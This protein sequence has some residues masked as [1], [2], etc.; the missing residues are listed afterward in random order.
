MRRMPRSSGV[1]VDT[2]AHNL[3]LRRRMHAF[4]RGRGKGVG[5]VEKRVDNR[6]RHARAQGPAP[7]AEKERAGIL[8]TLQIIPCWSPGWQTYGYPEE[9]ED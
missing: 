5:I 1:G 4:A 7:A 8:I 9:S 3:H 6:G 2:A